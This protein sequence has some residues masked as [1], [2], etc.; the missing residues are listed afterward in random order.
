MSGPSVGD[1]LKMLLGDGPVRAIGNVADAPASFATRAGL[2]QQGV[3]VQPVVN[4]TLSY[5]FGTQSIGSPPA[6]S[7]PIYQP[8]PSPA[9]QPRGPGA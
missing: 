1:S 5:N 9:L 6:P 2:G 3:P 7:V 8:Q 4:P